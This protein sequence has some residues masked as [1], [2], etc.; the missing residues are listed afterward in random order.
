MYQPPTLPGKGF[1]IDDYTWGGEIDIEDQPALPESTAMNGELGHYVMEQAIA[2]LLY[3]TGFEGTL[4]V[5][6]LSCRFSN[7]GVG[8]YDG[9]SRGIPTGH[10]TNSEAL[11]K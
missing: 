9:S 8:C 7:L 2:K 6:I 5:I 10:W 1:E 4:L 11:S 3:H